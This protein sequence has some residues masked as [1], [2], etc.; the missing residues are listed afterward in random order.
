MSKILGTSVKEKYS[1]LTQKNSFYKEDINLPTTS[2][3]YK[4]NLSESKVLY[5]VESDS[6]EVKVKNTLLMS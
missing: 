5:Y 6:K 3:T 4:E 2:R 1:Q